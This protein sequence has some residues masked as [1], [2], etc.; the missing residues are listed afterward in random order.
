METISF[1]N[2][3]VQ[4]IPSLGITAGVIGVVFLYVL[5]AI[6]LERKISAHVQ[7][8]L[9]PME[10]GGWH[11]WS[12][13]IADTLKLL[14]K[15]DIIPS[16]ADKI[17]FRLAPYVVI[18]GAIASFAVIPLGA[19]IVGVDLNIGV[20]YIV[21]ISSLTVI[22]ILMAGWSSHNKWA[23][24]GAM[25]SAAQ[26]VSYEIPIGLSLLVPLLIHGTMSL[27]ELVSV[28]E[29][30]FWRWTIFRVP[31]FALIAFLIYFWASLAETN[32]TP[33]DIPEA[34]SELVAGYHTEYSGMR[35]AMFFLAEY[36]NMFLVSLVASI[37]FLGGWHAPFSAW[38]V[39]P[40]THPVWHSILGAFWVV[41]KGLGLVAVQ[42]WIRWTLPRLRVDQLMHLCWKVLLPFSFANVLLSSLWVVIKA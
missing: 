15:E 4:L 5:F 24:Y 23:L 17:L 6:W 2:G 31:P 8:R 40:Q 14:I 39:S 13:T 19:F 20:Y 1:F 38:E 16:A 21:A 36:A 27:Q 12:Q 37:L 42:M 9:G 41:A 26:M 10:T 18:V 29:G 25:R 3:L 30:G 7:D 35:F 22:G 33:F 11:G 34:E 28:Q 32:R